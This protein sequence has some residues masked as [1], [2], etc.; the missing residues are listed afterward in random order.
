MFFAGPLSFRELHEVPCVP[1]LGLWFSSALSLLK[2]SP[3]KF[4][5]IDG[6]GSASLT[7]RASFRNVSVFLIPGSQ[8][9]ESNL[10]VRPDVPD[11]FIG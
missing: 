9:L 1:H 2:G 4:R 6:A 11:S 10:L 8:H 3:T 7:G 5:P